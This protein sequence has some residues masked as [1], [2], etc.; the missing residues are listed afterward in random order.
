MNERLIQTSSIA[1]VTLY[2]IFV[3]WIY[4]AAPRDLAQ[5]PAKARETV[6]NLT[7]KGEVLTGTYE[8]DQ[9]RFADALLEFRRDNFVAARDGFERADPER[10]DARTQFYIAYSLYRQGFGKVFNDDEL[11][12]RGLAQTETVIGIDRDFRS[13]DPDLKLRTPAEL[14]NEFEEGLRVTADDLNPL[15]LVRE[16]K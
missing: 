4:A 9:K 2:G 16:R 11:Y 6:E 12:K 15:K 1:L 8:V 3:V 7:T 13:D 14:K 5:V 10:R